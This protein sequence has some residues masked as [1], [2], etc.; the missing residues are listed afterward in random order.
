MRRSPVLLAL[1]CAL[2]LPVTGC[3]DGPTAPTSYAQEVHGRMWV[4]VAEPDGLPDARTWAPYLAPESP[5]VAELR[6][7]SSAAGRARRALRLEEAAALEARASTT[8]AAAVGRI[9]DPLPLV[10]ALDALHRWERNAAARLE[11]GRY[12]ELE[13]A[14]AEVA[15]LRDGARALLARGDTA[16]AVVQLARAAE[17]VRHES[18]AAVALRLVA[19]AE[20]RIDSSAAPTEPM[21]RARRLLRGAREGM[22]TG[23]HARALR[24]AVYALQLL[25]A[26]TSRREPA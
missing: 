19:A 26:E 7:L 25:E 8:A 24:R 18:P 15:G 3:G 9:T 17:R 12:V 22:A 20:A 14:V 6:E 4:A 16:A 23:D 21:R 11:S 13:L 2:V 10:R 5:I 1:A